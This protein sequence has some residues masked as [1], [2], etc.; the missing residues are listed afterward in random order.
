M[1]KRTADGKRKY[2]NVCA[3]GCTVEDKKT[4]LRGT[5]LAFTKKYQVIWENGT[6]T[7]VDAKTIRKV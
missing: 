7:W 2:H 5:L 1:T 6:T 3:V 4:G